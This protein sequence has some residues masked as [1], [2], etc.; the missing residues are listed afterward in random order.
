MAQI[1]ARE[2]RKIEKN[3]KRPRFKVVAATGD[4]KFFVE[5]A[6]KRELE[7]IASSIG[8]ELVFLPN[9]GAGLGGEK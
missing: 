6:R 5:H 4:I 8:A 2:R 7:A 3:E 1:F 9:D